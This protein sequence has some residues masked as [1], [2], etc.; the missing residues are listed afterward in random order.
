[1]VQAWRSTPFKK[2]D[3]DSTLVMR[4]V[5]VSASKGRIEI[6]H[7]NVPDQDFKGV[8]EGWKKY[9]WQPWRKVLRSR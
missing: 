4:F 8:T 2:S 3:I 7:V 9:Y 5:P 6:M 1:M